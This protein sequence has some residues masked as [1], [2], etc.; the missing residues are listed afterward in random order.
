MLMIFIKSANLLHKITGYLLNLY[1]LLFSLPFFLVKTAK[2]YIKGDFLVY[3]FKDSSKKLQR[4]SFLCLELTEDG[5][6]IS[7]SSNICK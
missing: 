6:E 5:T 2:T 7:L 1:Q 4:A 3:D